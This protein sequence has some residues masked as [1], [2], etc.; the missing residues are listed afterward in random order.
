MTAPLR[1]GVVAH[2]VARQQAASQATAD[3]VLAAVTALHHPVGRRK[4]RCAECDQSFPCRTARIVK[5]EA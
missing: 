4:P 3:A 2:H 5:G 1:P